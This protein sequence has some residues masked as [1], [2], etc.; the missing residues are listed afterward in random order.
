MRGLLFKIVKLSLT[1]GILGGG[2]LLLQFVAAICPLL[3]VGAETL[4]RLDL[5]AAHSSED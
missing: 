5:L 2:Y 3:R 1:A 4:R